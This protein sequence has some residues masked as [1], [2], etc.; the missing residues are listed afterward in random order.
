MECGVHS[1]GHALH[2]DPGAEGLLWGFGFSGGDGKGSRSQGLAVGLSPWIWVRRWGEEV[3][4]QLWG[5]VVPQWPG[6][7]LWEGGTPGCSG[8]SLLIAQHRAWPNVKARG[9]TSYGLV[10]PGP[11]LARVLSTAWGPV[12]CASEWRLAKPVR[13]H[14]HTH[15]PFLLCPQAPGFVFSYRFVL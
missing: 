6:A 10:S 8:L 11:V 14:T 7:A 9:N 1:S 4:S 5:A 2:G 3:K 12:C 13:L 15:S